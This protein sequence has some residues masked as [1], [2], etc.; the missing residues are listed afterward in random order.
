MSTPGQLADHRIQLS[1]AHSPA[2]IAS[3]RPSGQ[4]WTVHPKD[5]PTI[6][7]NIASADGTKP[8]VIEQ[9]ELSGNV[10]T[11]S[12]KVRVTTPGTPD[13]EELHSL[14][15]V[16]SE[17]FQAYNNGQPID[18]ESG[19]IVFHE[20]PSSSK[21]GIVG[22][23]VHITVL[24][25]VKA[26]APY[27][28]KLKVFACIQV[29]LEAEE[30]HRDH[31][32]LLDAVVGP[33]LEGE[34]PKSPHHA[35]EP[36]DHEPEDHHEP[37]IGCVD[38][39]ENPTELPDNRIHILPEG[40]GTPSDL[41]PNHPTKGLPVNPEDKPVITLDL[42]AEDGRLPGLLN[43][44][45]VHGNVKEV[46]VQVKTIRPKADRHV[47]P[48]EGTD[49]EGFKDVNHGKPIDVEH[50]P[51]SFVNPE[52]HKPGQMVYQVRITLLKPIKPNEPYNAKL[53]VVACVQNDLEIISKGELKELL[54]HLPELMKH[55]HDHHHD[56]Q[57]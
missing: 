44:I 9:L 48:T 3:L 19:T 45:G 20:S 25:P 26:D 52:T 42:T 12:I 1:P 11:V 17:G 31:T 39:M 18:V 21:S 7:I 51:I 4:G 57:H 10:K 28:L 8:G 5:T 29:E 6:N 38:I 33:C 37:N 30:E 53:S 22:H 46:K 34:E 40:K 13:H 15:H 14:G 56:H 23:Q 32:K 55:E 54:E 41:R 36:E 49:P 47:V 16:D 50:E 27:S 24:S 43:K 2:T 35:D